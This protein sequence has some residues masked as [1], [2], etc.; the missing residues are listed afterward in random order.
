MSLPELI[1]A[2]MQNTPLVK[3]PCAHD[4]MGHQE[5]KMKKR[6]KKN[7]NQHGP[8]QFPSRHS[9]PSQKADILMILAA[10]PSEK[11]VH[12]VGTDRSEDQQ[13]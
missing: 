13:H 1:N 4:S 3:T 9:A 11:S 6:K 2:C 7:K 10:P 8:Y 12:A 5:V